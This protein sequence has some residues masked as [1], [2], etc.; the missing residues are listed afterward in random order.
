[1]TTTAYPPS[2]GG[3]QGYL[4]DL[5]ARLEKFE[6]EVLTMW[7]ERR[8]DWLLGSTLRLGPSAPEDAKGVR[9]IGWS[10]SARM[11]MAP[12]VLG[13][14]AMVPIAARRIAA[15]MVPELDRMIKPD[16]VLIH[17][18]RIGREFLAMASL[19]VARRRGLPFILTPYHHPRWHG[20]R[21]SAWIDVYKSAD[22]VLTLTAAEAEELRRLGVEPARLHVIGGAADD[23]MPADAERFR[24]KIG[25]GTRPIVLFLGQLYE[26]KGV[27][28]LLSA[29]QS[30]RANGTELELVFLGPETEFSR[31][32][33]ANRKQAWVHVMGAVD[34]QT[35]WD[36]I[37]AA[38]V[39]CVPSSQESFGRV[40]LEAWAKGK[41]VIG[42]RIPPVMEVVTDGQN[43][44]LV[45]PGSVNHL[46]SAL[47]LLLTDEKLAR[48]LGEDGR[49]E[50][51]KR[52]TWKQ[53]VG[54]VEA[55][56]ETLLARVASC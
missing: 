49:Q 41:P 53:V 45:A 36:A 15:A 25:A 21:Y 9:R 34:N 6:A 4:A 30:L 13:Y 47:E 23:P 3:V 18:H 5:C 19:A 28:K 52:F 37:E 22:A 44:L 31:G 26:Y 42:G 35:K 11:R 20:Y 39:V 50:L 1:M 33:F 29:A 2:I 48:R 8:T 38:T 51:G 54:R 12:W 7:L 56:Y 10:S 32:L 24:S 14:Y 17:N 55:V 43:G 27:S 16:H 46:E 40:Y